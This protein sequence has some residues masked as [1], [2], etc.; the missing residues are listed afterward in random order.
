MIAE[1]FECDALLRHRDNCLLIHVGVVNAHS[2]EY[3]KSLHEV[4]IVL[5]ETLE[6]QQVISDLW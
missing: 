1:H 2:A 5:G 4:L 3:R 6:M